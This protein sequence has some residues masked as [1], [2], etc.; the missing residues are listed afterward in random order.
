V[1][2]TAEVS[3]IDSDE[4]KYSLPEVSEG[5]FKVNF[6]LH[7]AQKY[8]LRISYQGD[9]YESEFEPVPDVPELDSVYGF[10]ETRILVQ[11][12]TDD[13]DDFRRNTGVMLY[14]DID[15]NGNS[16]Y[17]R[18]NARKTYQYVFN[19]LDPNPEV[20]ELTIFAWDTF[21]PFQS[22]FNVAAP[23]EYSVSDDIKKHALYFME[24]TVESKDFLEYKTEENMV[25][26]G[27]EE[28][29]R[30]TQTIRMK[31]SK[32]V[33]GAVIN[34]V[35]IQANGNFSFKLHNKIKALN[36]LAEFSGMAKET[37]VNVNI[38]QKSDFDEKDIDARIKELEKKINGNA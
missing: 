2:K 30:I 17:Y 22:T 5:T 37:Q 20:G 29:P 18:F 38:N 10:P 33:D 8:R 1:A 24:K 23:S 13:V 4:L 12:G 7:S 3:L 15:N 14:A 27:Q 11:G 16:K 31:D 28:Y 21:S 6:P 34:E 25:K 32:D 26:C 35:S 9:I 36:K 19:V